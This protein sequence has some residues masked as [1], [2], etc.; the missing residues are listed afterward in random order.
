MCSINTRTCTLGVCVVNDVTSVARVA[1]FAPF[2]RTIRAS[3]GL[4]ILARAFLFCKRDGA[5]IMCLM[6]AESQFGV[7]PQNDVMNA[8]HSIISFS[9]FGPSSTVMPGVRHRDTNVLSS[10]R[11][12]S[13]TLLKNMFFEYTKQPKGVASTDKLSLSKSSLTVLVDP[14]AF[15]AVWHSVFEVMDSCLV[16]HLPPG[17]CSYKAAQK[18]GGCSSSHSSA[19]AYS[20]VYYAMKSHVYVPWMH[21]NMAQQQMKAWTK[22]Y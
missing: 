9:V 1:P 8:K 16:G 3:L 5:C 20:S 18:H 13:P 10:D 7:K 11:N 4:T 2:L 14:S 6:C 21:D 22:L 15:A 12:A 17:L 19:N